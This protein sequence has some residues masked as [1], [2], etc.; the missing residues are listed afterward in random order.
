MSYEHPSDDRLER[1]TNRYML[2]GVVLMATMAAAF[3]LYRWFEPSWR[4]DAREE[5]AEF[6][7]EEGAATW[8]NNCSSCHGI[9]G[10]GGVAPALNSEQ[11]LQS[12]TDEQIDSLISVGIP[13]TLMS[14]FSLDHGGSLTTAQIDA[15]V[16]YIR[17]WEPDAPDLPGW[18]D[19]MDGDGEAATDSAEAEDAGAEP[20]DA[21]EDTTS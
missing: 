18:R 5:Q 14:A 12:A 13:G 9:T 16:A 15:I 3:P 11:F 10:E 8:Q 20:D 6:L 7:A 4:E 17:S 1:S 21:A 2:A 19:M